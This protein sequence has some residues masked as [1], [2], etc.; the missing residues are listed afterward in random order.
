MLKQ[1]LAKDISN[2]LDLT[3]GFI[4]ETLVPSS[5]FI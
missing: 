4:S 3:N 1:T 2:A 5:V